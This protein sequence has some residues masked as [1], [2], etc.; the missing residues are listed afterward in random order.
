MDDDFEAGLGSGRGKARQQQA[1]ATQAGSGGSGGSGGRAQ[2]NRRRGKGSGN[3]GKPGVRL[4][5][6]DLQSHFGV[7]L[8]EAAAR[9]GICP[10]T[11]KRACRRHGI[12]RWPRRQL[13]K[14]RLGG[15]A[16]AGAGSPAACACRAA[17]VQ[18]SPR[19]G[20]ARIALIS[21]SPSYVRNPASACR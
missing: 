10:T 5:L 6:E 3:P 19:A 17:G 7:G 8:K 16:G 18:A 4:R 9:L 21:P 2:P 20:P 1:K 12:Q 14:A 15:A 11:L 13:Q